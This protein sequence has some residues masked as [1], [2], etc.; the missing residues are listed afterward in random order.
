MTWTL[1]LL[2][3]VVKKNNKNGFVRKKK[4]NKHM[5]IVYILNKKRLY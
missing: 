4:I 3:P 2:F 1:K 5:L